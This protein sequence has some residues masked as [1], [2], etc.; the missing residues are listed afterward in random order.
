MDMIP[1]KGGMVMTFDVEGWWGQG[2]KNARDD[3][4]YREQ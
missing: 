1:Y 2:Q 3:E 4:N